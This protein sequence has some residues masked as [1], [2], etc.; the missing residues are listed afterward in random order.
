MDTYELKGKVDVSLNGVTI[1]AY[2]VAEDGVTTTVEEKTMEIPSMDG[3]VTVGTGIYDNVNSVFN[4]LLPNMDY[5][6]NILP[7]EFENGVGENPGRLA[8]G[9]TECTVRAN[10]PLVIHY[11]C[12]DDS[13][14]DIYLP[15]ASIVASF[16]LE[17]TGSD[18][19]MIA[20]TANAQP[21]TIEEH[22]G[23][24]IFFGAGSLTEATLWN[25]EAEEYEPVGSS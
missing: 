15:N 18:P 19:V 5:F 25:A 4:I 17:Q 2:L 1:P 16:E 13:R 10:T 21:S 6:K 23:K 12:Q 11:S 7:E 3:T 9:G 8:L 24:K 22:N 14:N 20:I